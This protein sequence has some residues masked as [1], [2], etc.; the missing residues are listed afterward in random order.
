MN[1]KY[2]RRNRPLPLN[3]SAKDKRVQKYLKDNGYD[4]YDERM[5]IIGS[6]QHDIPN[7]RLDKG[8]FLL[9]LCRM[10]CDGELRNEQCVF[11]IDNALKYIHDGGHTD[12]FDENINGKSADELHNM[13]RE[14][15]QN[16]A[17]NDRARSANRKFNG[18]SEYTIIPIDSYEEAKPY[19]K[20]TDWCVTY[21]SDA[22]KSYTKGGN[23]FYFCLKN[24]F[25]DTPKDD[26]NA[27]I[28]EYGLSMIAVNIDMDG[29]LT[30][31]TTRYNHDYN[32]ENNPALETAEQLEDVL[33]VPFY[34]TFK[35]YTREELM[36]RGVVLFDMVQ[37]LL[38]SG[39]SLDEIF[40]TYKR[41]SGGWYIVYLN[42][43]CNYITEDGKIAS[44]DLWFSDC[45]DCPDD[46]G[47]RR[48]IID[49]KY[50]RIDK[51][52]RLISPNESFDDFLDFCNDEG[53]FYATV[54][55][56]TKHNIITIDGRILSPDMW[57]KQC[58]YDN[59]YFM[60]EI[61]GKRNIMDTDGKL[62][63]PDMWFDIIFSHANF[64]LGGIGDE[65]Y[66]VYNDGT[67]IA[68][69]DPYNCSLEKSNAINEAFR[70]SI[71]RYLYNEHGKIKSISDGNPT[72]GLHFDL[73]N[74][75][76]NVLDGYQEYDFNEYEY[77]NPVVITFK[78]GYKIIFEGGPLVEDYGT[79]QSRTSK[80][81][82]GNRNSGRRTL[83]E[84]YKRKYKNKHR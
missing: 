46:C 65:W 3:E 53:F 40:D 56:G 83:Y 26:N 13:F 27:P 15:G 84:S 25:E 42:K 70:S 4:N 7:A 62:I 60:V 24:G 1:V 69:N 37:E 80:R 11:N 32:G 58:Y 21:N 74:V 28:N 68:E 61:D 22:F 76:D 30:R 44:P 59:G 23:R 38:D 66:R 41:I 16:L 47:T 9:G 49:G 34:K 19:G 45:Y 14:I 54:T 17:S 39:K 77:D 12:E 82:F 71:L 72:N 50:N 8:K 73:A 6:I 2:I 63:S 36:E 43:K 57:F 75:T 33:N 29:N 79:W 20:Y 64:W 35:P 31:V 52:G 67:I 55:R 10:Y 5:R 48:V 18:K 51:N 78:D 81:R